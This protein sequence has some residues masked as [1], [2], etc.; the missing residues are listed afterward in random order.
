MPSPAGEIHMVWGLGLLGSDRAADAAKVF[1]RAID[2]KASDDAAANYFYLSGALALAD[3]PDEA[4]AAAQ[5]AAD[6]KPKSARFRARPAWVLY[7]A[8]RY[9]EAAKV[10]RALVDQMDSDTSDETRD[11]LRDA[12][13]ALSNLCVLQGDAA[14]A[15][16]WLEQVLDEFPD[17]PGALNELGLSLGGSRHALVAGTSDD[18]DGRLGRA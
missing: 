7:Y 8:K 13:L 2:E 11:V 9:D 18:R 6:K 3:R 10:Y 15:E 5:T 12:R 16:D 4:L 17:D 14:Q 1:Q